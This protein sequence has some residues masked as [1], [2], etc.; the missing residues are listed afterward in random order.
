MKKIVSFFLFL[1]ILWCEISTYCYNLSFYN[2]IIIYLIFFSNLINIFATALGSKFLENLI[3]AFFISVLPAWATVTA[4]AHGEPF[5]YNPDP[6]TPS[7]NTI[8]LKVAIWRSAILILIWKHRSCN[9]GRKTDYSEFIRGSSKS[10]QENDV[11]V[12]L[13]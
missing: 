10:V 7:C 1:Y 5:I 2:L 3:L 11:I 13:F 4:S 12:N 9:S 8:T 6:L